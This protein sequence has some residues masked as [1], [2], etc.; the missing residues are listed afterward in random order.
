[1]VL[2][3]SCLELW[4]ICADVRQGL[5]GAMQVHLSRWLRA[6]CWAGLWG[7]RLKLSCCSGFRTL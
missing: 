6:C 2:I 1:M 5:F 3:G 7:K 4:L